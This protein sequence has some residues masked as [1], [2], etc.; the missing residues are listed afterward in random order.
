VLTNDPDGA[1]YVI[2]FADTDK[3]T[4][5]YVLRPDCLWCARNLNNVQ[6]LV[7]ARSASFRFIGLSLSSNGVKEYVRANSLGFPVYSVASTDIVQALHLGNT[8]QTIVVTSRGK[9]IQDW[10][11]AYLDTNQSGV[12]NFFKVKLPGLKTD[13]TT[14][15][16]FIWPIQGVG[17]R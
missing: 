7:K 2:D 3:S 4:V 17:V 1:I 8:P 9:V 10:I 14:P 5:L 16:S 12:E 6:A 11:G 15:L 13:G